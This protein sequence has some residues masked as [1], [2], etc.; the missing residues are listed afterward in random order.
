V[1]DRLPVSI[2]ELDLFRLLQ[3]EGREWQSEPLEQLAKDLASLILT[4]SSLELLPVLLEDYRVLAGCSNQELE[5]EA[6]ERELRELQADI[7]ALK[8]HYCRQR[9]GDLFA[10]HM[11]LPDT[12]ILEFRSPRNAPPC[13]DISSVSRRTATR[14]RMRSFTSCARRV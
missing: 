2:E 1:Y 6:L 11:K 4:E 10:L 3:E 8:V 9:V 5:V 7:L 13:L 14:F 12:L